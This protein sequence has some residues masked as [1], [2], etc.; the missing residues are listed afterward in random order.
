MQINWYLRRYKLWKLS[1][2]LV[3]HQGNLLETS[4]SCPKFI[5]KVTPQWNAHLNDVYYYGELLIGNLCWLPQ[6]CQDTQVD[7][8]SLRLQIWMWVKL[9]TSRISNIPRNSS[10]NIRKLSS[11]TFRIS[12]VYLHWPIFHVMNLQFW[13]NL[14]QTLH[15]VTKFRRK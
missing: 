6:Y 13:N 9:N 15:Y 12:A 11:I 1:H 4:F 8:K 7:T 10:D 14:F 5:W 2:F 3:S